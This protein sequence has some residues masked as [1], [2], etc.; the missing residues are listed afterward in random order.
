MTASV[1]VTIVTYNNA[2]FISRCLQY[3]FEQDHP[4]VQVFIV[5]NASADETPQILRAFEPRIR[6][7]YN[8]ENIGFAAAQ[9]QAIALSNS[10]WVLTLNPDVRLTPDFLS[11][12]LAAGESDPVIGSVSGKLL[13][14]SAD[15]EIPA[16]RV[17][18]STG[19]YFTPNIRHFDRGSKLPDNG[20]YDR[21]EYVFGVTGATALYR[22]RMI[23]DI[24]IFGEFFD[25]DFFAYREDADVAWRAQLLG[26]KC[27]YT[28]LAVAYHVRSVLPS[29]RRSVA[30]LVNMHSV[31][32]RFLLRS[33]NITMRLWLRHYFSFVFRDLLVL[34][35]CL[36]RE[37]TSL[38]AFLLLPR[39]VPRAWRKRRAIMGRRRV[40]YAYLA[41]WFSSRPMSYPAPEIPAAKAAKTV[42]PR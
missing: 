16:R 28:P 37:W 27:L 18:D 20:Q 3:V 13:A 8:R 35:G 9:N 34:G 23:E 41:P 12:M 5:D 7:V 1:A 14:M 39:L 21:F 42:V 30:P 2:Q 25:S 15:F 10:D 40:D 4:Y 24:S 33:K 32:N 29:N 19:I 26:W 22:R 31:K 17:F 38:R 11:Q 36:L 6:V